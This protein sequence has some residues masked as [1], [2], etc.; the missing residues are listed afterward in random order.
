[1]TT[2]SQPLPTSPPAK[3]QADKD[4]RA[5]ALGRGAK[6]AANDLDKAG[7]AYSMD[8][9][10]EVLGVS[11]QTVNKKIAE[12]ELFAVPGS[13]HRRLFPRIQFIRVRGR[14]VL[15]KGLREV[16]SAFPSKNPWMLLNFLV[17]SD[18]RLN[19]RTPIE[20]LKSG[21]IALVVEAARRV[22]EQGA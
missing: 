13:N 16:T 7:G 14:D 11:L 17:N 19:R 5:R 10:C 20:V 2:A 9:V 3:Q 21:D 1:M 12:G 4:A 6:I 15:V 18:D 8:Q 22:G